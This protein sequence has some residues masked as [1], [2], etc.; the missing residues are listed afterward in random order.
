MGCFPTFIA[1]ANHLKATG[2]MAGGIADRWELQIGIGAEGEGLMV[3]M[4]NSHSCSISQPPKSDGKVTGM[5]MGAPGGQDS[6]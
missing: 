4:P 3:P 1:F 5:T 2:T 6:Q